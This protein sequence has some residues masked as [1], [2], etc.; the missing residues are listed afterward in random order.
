MHRTCP[1]GST[2]SYAECCELI[3]L[4][5]SLANTAEQLMRARYVGFVLQKIDFLYNTFHPDSRRFQKKQAI[6]QWS[7]ENS[8][9]GLEIV[10]ST[11]NTVEF[12]AHYLD[13]KHESCIHHEKSQFKKLQNRWFYFNGT[14]LD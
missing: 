9:Q 3:H 14:I 2:S 13:K 4:N 7:K 1:C 5:A 8:W 6:E 12:K 11:E 10:K